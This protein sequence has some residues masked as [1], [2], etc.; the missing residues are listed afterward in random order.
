M[1]EH[2]FFFIG[3]AAMIF[4]VAFM[5]Y[6]LVTIDNT[7]RGAQ[8]IIANQEQ[9]LTTDAYNRAYDIEGQCFILK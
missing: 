9:C 8:Y 4:A 7:V 3:I 2:I 1:N 5:I 6:T